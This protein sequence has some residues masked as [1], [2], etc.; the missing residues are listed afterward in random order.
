MAIP[1]V[2][3]YCWFGDKEK[4]E[5]VQRCIESWKKF[6]PDYEIREWSEKNFDVTIN[7]YCSQAYEKKVWGF[8]PDFIRLWIVYHYGG[9]YLDTDVQIIKSLDPLL[10]N[11]AF[12][13]FEWNTSEKKEDGAYVNFGQGFGAEAYNPVIKAHMDLYEGVDFVLKD[14]S[15]NKLPSPK[16]TT[17]I[18]VNYGL[19][20]QSNNVQYLDDITVYPSDYFCPKDYNSGTIRKTKNTYSIHHYDASWLPEED[21][22]KKIQRWASWRRDSIR[23]LPNRIIKKLI[24]QEVYDKVKYVFRK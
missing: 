9:I 22:E 7:N 24:G 1:K 11:K 14:G 12:A 15:L 18:L 8:V 10:K 5:S 3:H 19:N 17:K 4:P 2:I 20:R 21:N 23:H 6:C 16:Y 13:G